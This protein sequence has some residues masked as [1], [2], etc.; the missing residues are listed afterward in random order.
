M[1]LNIL[2]IA[3]YAVNFM[4]TNPIKEIQ[5]EC[6]VSLRDWGEGRVAPV[7]VFV[8]SRLRIA[9]PVSSQVI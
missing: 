1:P 5:S 4:K 9:K 8:V 2:Y 6:G 7:V 3:Y